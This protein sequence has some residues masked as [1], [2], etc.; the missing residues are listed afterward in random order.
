ML[1]I[2]AGQV[3]CSYLCDPADIGVNGSYWQPEWHHGDP[4]RRLDRT[5]Q[6]RQFGSVCR[7]AWIAG[8]STAPVAWSPS[9]FTWVR[10]ALVSRLVTNSPD[11]ILF[12]AKFAPIPTR[13]LPPNASVGLVAHDARARIVTLKERLAQESGHTRICRCDGTSQPQS[14]PQKE[15]ICTTRSR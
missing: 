5:G 3:G 4:S 13:P 12:N 10:A 1:C 11:R 14:A 9:G 8:A 15:A 7:N 6:A 2:A